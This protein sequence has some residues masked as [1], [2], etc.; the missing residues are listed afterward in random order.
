MIWGYHYFW[1]HPYGNQLSS[2]SAGILSNTGVLRFNF[3]RAYLKHILPRMIK[4]VTQKKGDVTLAVMSQNHPFLNKSCIT[5]WINPPKQTIHSAFPPPPKKKHIPKIHSPTKKSQKT[6]SPPKY[7]KN[8]S[9]LAS[10]LRTDQYLPLPLEETPLIHR[11]WSCNNFSRASS[12]PT[13]PISSLGTK[14]TP[15]W[16]QHPFRSKVFCMF[17][18][19]EGK[20][21]FSSLLLLLLLSS[22]LSTKK[23]IPI[24][25]T[26]LPFGDVNLVCENRAITVFYYHLA[27]DFGH[28]VSKLGDVFFHWNV[29]FQQNLEIL[30]RHKHTP[31]TKTQTNTHTHMYITCIYIYVDN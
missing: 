31:Q 4:D 6:P 13:K 28:G 15:W 2:I 16:F 10:I 18:C 1:K 25:L 22:S 20:C 14:P 7:P 29:C 3:P 21:F 9:K 19:H 27:S 30:G 26:N 24:L 11:A 17:S 23:R 12:A 8:P 5:C